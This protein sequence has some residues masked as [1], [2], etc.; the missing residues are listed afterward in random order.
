MGK[1]SILFLNY[2]FVALFCQCQSAKRVVS[3]CDC[4]SKAVQ[5]SLIEKYLKNGADRYNYNGPEWQQ[6]CDSL[7]SL[8]PNIAV[9]Y[10]QKAIPFIKNGEYEK[11]FKLEDKAVELEPANYVAYRGFLKCIFTKDYEN[12]IVDFQK[13]EQ[14]TQ[15]GFVM[16]HTYFFYEG[17]CDLELGN[18]LRAGDD[19]KQDIFIQQGGDK[20]KAVHFNTLL[21]AGILYYLIGNDD[22]AKEYLLECLDL[23]RQSPDA[24]Y[25]LALVYKRE[26]DRTRKDQYLQIARQ[27][28]G[29]KY[30]LNEDNVYYAYYPFQI[31]LYEVEQEIHE[32]VE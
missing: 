21:Y 24:N 3:V 6:Y 4:S 23:Y 32:D 13:A 16:D 2:L 28:I 7:I 19:F 1:S 5:D 8:C 18:Y 12:A 10:Q 14:L 27:S 31:T 17:L 30:G 26:H 29:Q 15:G 11:A 9:A 25:Y 22:K 20:T